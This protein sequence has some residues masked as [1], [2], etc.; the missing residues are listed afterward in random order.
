MRYLLLILGLSVMF[1]TVAVAEDLGSWQKRMPI[2]FSGYT[3][4]GGGTLTNFP[5]L[6]ILS[7][8]NAG[9][10]FNYS[11][12]LSPPYGDL[13]FAAAD[14][15]TP[16]DFEV[17]SWVSNGLSYIWVRVPELTNSTTI[18]ALWGQSGVT[19]PACTTN[20]AV[21]DV[22]YKGVWHLNNGSVLSAL[23]STTNRNNGSIAGATATGGKVDGA[24]S[25]TGSQSITTL[26]NTTLADFT[27]EVW[28]KDDGVISSYERLVDKKYDTGFWLG[29]NA[30][31]VNSWG[32][33]VLE[34]NSPYGVYI[35]LTDGMWHQ[36]V[37][38]RRGSTHYLYGDGGG[39]SAFNTV[40]SSSLDSTSVM[41]GN[42]STSQGFGGIVDEVRISTTA[43]ATNWIWACYM[44]MASN[45]LFNN[46]GAPESQGLPSVNNGNGATNI[47]LSTAYLNGALLTT[48]SSPTTVFAYWGASDGGTNTWANTNVWNAPQPLGG[49]TVHLTALSSNTTYYYRFAATN[50]DGASW[51]SSSSSFIT[52]DVWIDQ[53]SDASEIGPTPGTF[54]VHRAS[55]ATNELLVVNY[56]VSGT[57]SNGVDYTALS[58]SIPIP[59]GT[60]AV[61][62]VVSPFFDHLLEGME[63]VQV[64]VVSGPYMMG[65]SSNATLGITDA[66]TV[67]ATWSG[68]GTNALASNPANWVGGMA[69]M[70]GDAVVL[71]A[72]TNKNMTWDLNIPLQSWTQIGYTGTVT[73]ATVYGTTGFTNF[74]ISGNCVISNGLWTQVA[75]P[76]V[77]YESNRLS[78]TIGGNLSIGSNG[79]ID[80]TGKGYTADRGP[81]AC[82]S[83][84]GR[85]LWNGACYGSIVA[86]TNLGS[87]GDDNTGGGAI[88][89]TV[90]GE[91][92]N[93]GLLCADG[94]GTDRAGAGGSIWLISGTL[95]GGG[96]IRANGGATSDPGG[97][98]RISLVVTQAG[99]NFSLYTGPILATGGG[100]RAAGAGT[101]YRQRADQP[102]N[103][104][105]LI[106]D[107]Y[108]VANNGYTDINLNMAAPMVGDVILRNNAILLLYANQN[109]TVGG[110]WSNAATFSAQL[111]SQVI[112]AGDPSSTSM[113]YGVNTFMG[114]ICTNAGKTLLFQAGKTNTIAA[115]GRLTL[116]GSETSAVNLRSTTNG[117]AWK[118][119]VNSAAAQDVEHVDVKDSDAMTGVGAEVTAMNSQNSGNNQ[120]WRFI[121]V[122]AGETNVWTGNSNTVWS[123]RDNWSL[124][125]A[126]VVSDVIRI[127]AGQSRYPVLD[128]G[129]TVYELE[130]QSG[131]A[132]SLASYNLVVEANAVVAGTLTATGTETVTFLADA[133]FT[134]GTLVAARS[135]ISLAGAGDQA[136]NFGNQA[137]YKVAVM[138]SAGTVT[139]VNGFAATEL[140]C[141]APGGTR[142]LVFQQGATFTLRDLVML[143]AVGSTN[144]TLQSS[145]S[146]MKWNL[147]VSG[148]RCVRGV[149]VMDSDARMGLPIPAAFSMNS[150]NN[151]N[152]LFGAIPSVWLGSVNNNFHTASNWS[153][154]GVPDTTTRVLVDGTNPMTITGAVSVLDM[155]VGG[156]NGA[157]SVTVNA[158]L[159]VGENIAVLSNAT[160]TLN[161][162]SV[163]SNGLFVL[164]GGLLTHSANGATEVNKLNVSVYGDVGV[165]ANG[166]V[167]VTA[168][169]YSAYQGPGRCGS[170]GGRGSWSGAGPCYGSIVAPT[171][172]GSGGD[173]E[174]GGGAIQLTVRGMIRNDGLLCADGKGLDRAGSGGSIWL[175]SGTLIGGGTI[176][177]NGGAANPASGGRISLVV[178]NTGA[179]FSLYTGLIQAYAGG[180]NAGAGTIYKQRADQ[181]VTTG[182]LVL[183]NNNISSGSTEITPNITGT[184][185][186]DVL[187]RNGAYLLVY[188]N[189]TL[190]VGGVWSNAARFVA[191]WGSQVL[192]AG[193]NS[194]TSTVYGTNVFMGLTCTN[195]GRTLLFQAGKTNAIAA[196][197]VLTLRGSGSS[198]LMMRSTV[199]NSSWK[200]NVSSLA[201]QSVEHVDVKDSDAMTG[202]GAAV[203]ALYGVDNGGNTNWIF[204]AGGQTNVWTGGSNTSWAISANWSLGRAPIADDFVKIP[205]AKP[206]YPVL[207]LAVTVNGMELQS[208]ASLDLSGRDL[209]VTSDAILAGVLNAAGTETITFQANVDFT[210]G[211]FTPAR[212][213][214]LLAGG[215]DQS[216][217]LF[218]QTFYKVT[219]L[220][221]AGTVTFG[222]GFAAT[223]LRCEAPGGTRNLVF[224]Q[225]SMFTLRDFVLL[226]AVGST[227]IT[228]QSSAYGMKWNLAVSGYRCVRGVDVQDC[229]ASLGLPI[230]AVS[231]LDSSGNLNWTFNVPPSVWL[232][233]SNNNFHTAANWSP[234]GVPDAT[235]RVLVSTVNSMTITGAVTV[236]ELMVGGSTGAAS[237]T[238]NAPITVAET[239]T[240]LSNG[241]LTLNRPCVVSNGLYVL[242][243]GLLTHSANGSTEVNKLNV[244]VYGDVGVD[245]NGSVDVTSRG[246]GGWQGPGKCGSY[247]GHGSWGGGG[248][249]YGSLVA[250]TNCGSG[251]DTG[252]GGGAILMTVGGMIRNDGLLCADG[253]GDRAG[254]GGSIWLTSGTL[255][256]VGTIRA[257]GG[258]SNPGAGGRISLV[259]TNTGADFSLYTGSILA[260]GGGANAG[261]GTIYKQSAAD[262]P[263][264]GMVF[265]ANN[266]VT[267]GY[268]DLPPNLSYLAGEVDRAAFYVNNGAAIQL[269]SDLTVGDI[270]LQAANTKLDLNFQTLLVHSRQHALLGTVTNFGAIIWI[271]D[272]AGTVFS[273]R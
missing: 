66:G 19:A 81:G 201:G 17:E 101:V 243:G 212:S 247:G 88:L 105:T 24:A 248:P 172:C 176:R 273:I 61:V 199:D 122:N 104:G 56:T 263:G 233:T 108:N 30:S 62:L 126:P 60:D 82:G 93:D 209:T 190:T 161:Q 168:R 48:G 169:G 54:T 42:G 134:G 257:N 43:R 87:G 224:Y 11:E 245:A 152:W 10:G 75:N 121:T 222:D 124:G 123:A 132:L 114:L 226:G 163:V 271:P 242:S 23:D 111:G 210:G 261:A 79:A 149:G 240:V 89:L 159:T 194:S 262:R 94:M 175:T 244:T 151:Q 183:D 46:Y 145:A 241:T 64:T 218:H 107:N 91:I 74:N 178:T 31:S 49:F 110:T 141:E 58:G 265:L 193:G 99:A 127:P 32:G 213:V 143:G 140:R 130:I 167:D 102:L 95:V 5:A 84:G 65:A 52:G 157:V 158:P 18:Y 86:P 80:V 129:A 216:V 45:A 196:Y 109:L 266:G 137:L 98:G 44:N 97:G 92:R 214:V 139:F 223:E 260:F 173:S 2:T 76:A 182:T 207:G 147:A 198:N 67:T 117:M 156:S 239:I 177:A 116:V 208:G 206:R 217:N 188:S 33:G 253:G 259:V 41:I 26:L 135:T 14:K 28:F 165:D 200:L 215:G 133:D 203:S 53:L 72:T 236:L 100:S 184:V 225:G 171:N 16:L 90:G 269:K 191:Q 202:V 189:Q 83:Y 204:L 131:G 166:S 118:L 185:F 187:L 162:P 229:D 77:S 170:Y 211:T 160:L 252:P 59:A 25:F 29:R 254:S 27:V 120:N 103:G 15:T 119:N 146:G 155:I 4:P 73:I 150:G 40:S 22:N 232:G 36:I 34:A 267:S 39:V 256:G 180:A 37:S 228:L 268:T 57:A 246:Y 115:Q 230:A 78:V 192:L 153:P 205:A 106:V 63:T 237:V 231:S 264:R 144:I 69:P 21:W 154:A 50:Q 68:G 258:A 136:I 251:G 164:A 12:F 1:T 3:P 238:V 138:N 142:N 47:T 128:A 8:T 250:P 179:D 35:T 113:V 195:A 249:C 234:A 174:P 255:I 181:S 6:V 197:G 221:S 148:Y 235:T 13:R 70:A 125:R 20:G 51:A 219:V 227:N 96:S 272:V 38:L 85:G 55:A 9:V 186:G 71:D 112:F 7:N 270:W 220:N